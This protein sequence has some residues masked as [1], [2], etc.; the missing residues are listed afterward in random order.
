MSIYFSW[1]NLTPFSYLFHR[2]FTVFPDTGVQK[3]Q[4]NDVQ[5]IDVLSL[6]TV[7]KVYVEAGDTAKAG[8]LMATVDT[9]SV[10]TALQT[11]QKELSSL[12]SQ[13]EDAKDD[14]VST[15]I[16][17]SV[18]GRVKKIYAAKGDG[19]T[20]VMQED[21]ALALISLDG[22]MAVEITAASEHLSG[23]F[24]VAMHMNNDPVDHF[25]VFRVS[26]GYAKKRHL[27]RMQKK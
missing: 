15:K 6:L 5:D 23:V 19:V 25:C 3:M 12:D 9:V 7:D 18:S 26:T 2:M 8:D 13:I 20:D 10:K 24:C 22:K 17:S 4:E 16:K 27:Q 21:G 14:T 1:I 11:L